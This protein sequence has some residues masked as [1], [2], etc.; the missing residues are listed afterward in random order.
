MSVQAV[1]K[2]DCGVLAEL[3]AQCFPAGWAAAEIARLV[4]EPGVVALKVGD[5]RPSGFILVRQVADEAEILTLAV[6]PEHRREGMARAL[7]DAAAEV[8]RS[9]AA[10]RL[11]LEVSEA[12]TAAI[13][14]YTAAGFRQIGCRRRYYSDGTDALVMEKSLAQ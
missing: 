13:G 4:S 11:F 10:M 2:T 8:L 7:L 3:H 5:A 14:L 12:N 9:T 6:D 1:A